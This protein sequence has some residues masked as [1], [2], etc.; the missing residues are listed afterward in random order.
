MDSRQNSMKHPERQNSIL[1]NLLP[2]FSSF[3]PKE[4]SKKSNQKKRVTLTSLV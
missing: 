2:N 1:S 4:S 3:Y